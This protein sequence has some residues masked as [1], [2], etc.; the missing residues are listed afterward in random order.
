MKCVICKE[1]I[2]P[3]FL[4]KIKGTYYKVKKNDKIE[5]KP[6]CN[7][8]QSKGLIPEELEE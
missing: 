4:N 5:L 6:V 8:C 3:N 2:E 1:E 7:E